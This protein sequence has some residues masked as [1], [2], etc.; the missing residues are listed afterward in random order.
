[1]I[2]FLESLSRIG[3]ILGFFALFD[4]LAS[5]EARN[6]V[7]DYVFGFHGVTMRQF[8][9]STVRAGLATVLNDGRIS[10]LRVLRMSA[11]MAAVTATLAISSGG[12]S[13]LYLFGMLPKSLLIEPLFIIFMTVAS[14][15][16]DI[17][18]IRVT[19]GLFIDGWLS[20]LPY[21][22]RI[23]LDALVSAVL[24][25]ALGGVYFLI[26]TEVMPALPTI[27][28][29]VVTEGYEVNAF[30]RVFLIS[31]FAV[32]AFSTLCITTLQL[33]VLVVGIILRGLL[34]LTQLSSPLV[35]HTRLY[36]APFTFV[37]IALTLTGFAVD[38]VSSLLC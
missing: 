33:I 32:S 36:D 2:E 27:Y 31:A 6:T 38:G 16:S 34:L 23:F 37:G 8:E 22:L 26:M 9:N 5:R 35:L 7:A 14:I 15:P 25:V 12:E 11:I 24:I 13:F 19:K 20:I 30:T 29:Q 4:L 18:S 3:G 1:M 21:I 28:G 17:L 10:G